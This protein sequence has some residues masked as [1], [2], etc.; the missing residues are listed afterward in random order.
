M[1]G[2]SQSYSAHP[3]H[4]QRYNLVSL[5][6]VVLDP[7]FQFSV[8]RYTALIALFAALSS[9]APLLS[10]KRDGS[11]EGGPDLLLRRDGSTEGGPDLLLRDGSTI[12]GPDDLLKRDGSTEGGPDLLLRRDGSTTGGPDDLLKL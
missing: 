4:L 11:T 12:G 7:N 10:G 5:E 2:T 9:A 6:S 8:M 1:L 3:I